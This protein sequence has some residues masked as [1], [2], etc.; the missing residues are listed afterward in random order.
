MGMTAG[1]IAGVPAGASGNC[2]T[3]GC[4]WGWIFGAMAPA[5]GMACAGAAEVIG[6]GTGMPGIAGATGKGAA[7]TTGIG[8]GEGS[9]AAVACDTGCTAGCKI[10]TCTGGD[11]ATCAG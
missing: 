5:A 11:G 3:A 9:G 1:G 4:G 2:G 8:A 6:C 7:A 10:T